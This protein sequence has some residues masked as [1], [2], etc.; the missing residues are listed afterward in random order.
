MGFANQVL[1]NVPTNISN[2]PTIE[3]QFFGFSCR[4][5]AITIEES[6]PRLNFT[7]FQIPRFKFESS[8][9]LAMASAN[10]IND[11]DP[12]PSQNHF[13]SRVNAHVLR[14]FAI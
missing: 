4:T 9:K 14:G 3:A 2:E 7:K 8:Q 12:K 10:K 6:N 13:R 5:F 1:M 11:I